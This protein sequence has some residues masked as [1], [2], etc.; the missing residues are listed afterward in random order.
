MSRSVPGE[1]VVLNGSN[2]DRNASNV[3]GRN[4]GYRV[5]SITITMDEVD[6]LV[7][8]LS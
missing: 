1:V 4:V 3:N 5:S 8:F 6:K 7:M 2:S